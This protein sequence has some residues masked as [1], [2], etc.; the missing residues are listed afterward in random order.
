MRKQ[1]FR[2]FVHDIDRIEARIAEA[3]LKRV[4]TAG[5]FVWYLAVYTRHA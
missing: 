5:R 1:P 2:A 4:A 3:G